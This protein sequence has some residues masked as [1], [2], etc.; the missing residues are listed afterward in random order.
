MERKQVSMLIEEDIL[1]GFDDFCKDIGL[2]RAAA[3]TLFMKHCAVNKVLPFT[4]GE[5]KNFNYDHS[6]VPPSYVTDPSKGYR[7]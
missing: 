6:P 7:K 4:P 1:K 3:V 2:S 5:K